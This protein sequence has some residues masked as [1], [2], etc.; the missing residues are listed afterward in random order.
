MVYGYVDGFSRMIVYLHC[1]NNNTSLTVL[2]CFTEATTEYGIPSRVRADRGGENVLVADYMIL[3]RGT[4]RGSFICGRSVHNQRIERLWRD[5]YQGCLMLYYDLFSFMESE[6]ILNPID[7]IHL[8]CLH[9]VYIS[10]INESLN[11]LC[12]AWNHHPMSSSGNATPYQMWLISPRQDCISQVCIFD[13][14]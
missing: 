4:D 12:N 11:V 8:F 3:N 1:A 13:Y 5:V 14:L 6:N 2:Q 9:Y 7:D 10:R